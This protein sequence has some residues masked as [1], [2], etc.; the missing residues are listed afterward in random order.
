MK[1]NYV[2]FILISIV[3]L[4]GKSTC[5]NVYIEEN[6]HGY[7]IDHDTKWNIYGT[8]LFT[9][10]L[11]CHIASSGREV[12][13][14]EKSFDKE[15]KCLSD[16]VLNNI[17]KILTTGK[18][19][20]LQK[21]QRYKLLSDNDDY[22]QIPYENLIKSLFFL[23]KA[24]IKKPK[25]NI[26]FSPTPQTLTSYN[27]IA[28]YLQKAG[29]NEEAIYLLEK[30][31]AKFPQRTVAYYNLGDAYWAV[32]DKTKAIKAY[33]IYIE[34][35]CKAGKDKKIPALVIKRVST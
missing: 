13:L 25:D 27:N 34:Q 7:Y 14:E 32:G 8:F 19:L 24:S 4:H 3:V 29:A 5:K 9:N 22:K 17:H 30:I 20:S 33:T 6:G 12:C 21:I 23:N 15:L 1:K 26:I 18:P 10:D 11:S 35:M 28:Y 2:L 16:I 31:I